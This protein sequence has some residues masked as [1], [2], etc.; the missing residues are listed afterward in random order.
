VE[1]AAITG[2]TPNRHPAGNTLDLMS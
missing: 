2:A 1:T